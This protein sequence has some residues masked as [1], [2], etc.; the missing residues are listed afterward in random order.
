L[1]EGK[2]DYEGV[3]S[4]YYGDESVKCV[5]QLKVETKD[6]DVVEEKVAQLPE[7]EDLFLVTGR[8]PLQD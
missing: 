1:T 5:I 4:R 8:A 3:I 2:A 7:I 6:A